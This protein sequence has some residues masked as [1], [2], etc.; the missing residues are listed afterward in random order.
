[1]DGAFLYRLNYEAYK[2]QEAEMDAKIMKLSEEGEDEDIMPLDEAYIIKLDTEDEDF[3]IQDS[4]YFVLLIG[5]YD[6]D[7]DYADDIIYGLEESYARYVEL[8]N[9]TKDEMTLELLEEC[10]DLKEYFTPYQDEEV[11]EI[12]DEILSGEADYGE[13][14]KQIF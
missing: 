13:V 12:M 9:K 14:I 11:T 1:M 8:K 5:D 10:V 3:Y 6:F 4:G 2:K 7:C